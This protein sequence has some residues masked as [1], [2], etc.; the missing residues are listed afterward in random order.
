[1]MMKMKQH[2][3]AHIIIIILA[4]SSRMMIKMSST[5]MKRMMQELKIKMLNPTIRMMPM[6]H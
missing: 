5:M 4:S 2:R 1:M 6:R 3:I